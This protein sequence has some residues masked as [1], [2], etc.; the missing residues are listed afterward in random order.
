MIPPPTRPLTTENNNPKPTHTDEKRVSR[1]PVPPN[2]ARNAASD[3]GLNGETLL[4]R[5]ADCAPG[6]CADRRPMRPR[7][8]RD[9]RRPERAPSESWPRRQV[10]DA[11]SVKVR[12]M[13]ASEARASKHERKETEAETDCETDQIKIGPVEPCRR[14]RIRLPSAFVLYA[15]CPAH[16]WRENDCRCWP[17]VP[18]AAPRAGG[19]P[20]PACRESR[21]ATGKQRR[22]SFSRAALIST[23]LTS[24]SLREPLRTLQQPDIELA[25]GSTQVRSQLGVIALR[26][27][28][29]KTGMHL[30][31]LRQQRARGLRHVR[32]RA[33]FDLREIG[34]ADALAFAQLGANGAH[35]FELRHGTAQTAQRAFDFAQVANFLAQL[36]RPRP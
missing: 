20:I 25:F 21:P 10:R 11:V 4:L 13:Q 33:A 7:L 1:Y 3:G 27:I 32:A 18:A 31:K 2:H 34:L 9:R 29:Q 16:G 22:V 23:L 17:P 6:A 28:H 5:A 8:A 14:H 35:Q 19:R 24:G 36:H 15:C 12:Q 30:E 26:V